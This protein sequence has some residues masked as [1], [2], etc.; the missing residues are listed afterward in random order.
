MTDKISVIIPVYNAEKYIS[1]CLESVVRQTYKNLEILL[2]D[3]GS[4]DGSAGICQE[5][6]KK[7]ARIRL[8]QKENGGVSSARNLGLQEA[9]GEYVTFVDADDWIGERMLE[10]LRACIERDKSELAMCEFREVN[11]GDRKRLAWKRSGG[12][13][14]DNEEAEQGRKAAI[15]G[16][17]NTS[18]LSVKDYVEN[19]LLAGNTR[20]WS[21]LFDRKMIGDIR[22][23]EGITIGEDLLFLVDLLPYVKMVS[24]LKSGEYCYYINE[25][26]AMFSGFRPSYMDQ[27][28]CWQRACGKIGQLYPEYVYKGRIALFQAS[29]LTAGKLALL[30]RQERK[31]KAACLENCIQAAKEAARDRK[32]WKGLPAGYKVKGILFL[33]FPSLYLD[34]YHMWKCGSI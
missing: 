14:S 28:T 7:D 25:E 26:G 18:A 17:E 21:I 4:K 5:W 13:L 31:E 10:R 19:C 11:S 24:I 30:T 32:A 29:L 15:C 8:L 2:V 6:C 27:I 3:D 22:F 1:D 34:L 23:P 12:K 20:C 9:S 33:N 16:G